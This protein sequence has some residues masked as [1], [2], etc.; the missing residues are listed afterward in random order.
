MFQ[1]FHSL[2]SHTSYLK[3]LT[4]CQFQLALD[5]LL[6]VSTVPRRRLSERESHAWVLGNQQKSPHL[7]KTKS[8]RL[9][10]I[11]DWSHREQL[12]SAPTTTY[13]FIAQ[14]IASTL[15]TTMK[16]STVSA[17][18]FGIVLRLFFIHAGLGSPTVEVEEGGVQ[19]VSYHI[20]HFN[21]AHLVVSH[22]LLFNLL[23][24][25]CNI[26]LMPNRLRMVASS[27]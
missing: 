18:L 25:I 27:Q 11:S 13:L 3:L 23:L 1:H 2:T 8:I 20:Y 6:A 24:I 5:L 9:H 22:P 10:C 19:Q 16:H 17:A 4:W 12:P 7:I 15:V 14:R 26:M 21:M